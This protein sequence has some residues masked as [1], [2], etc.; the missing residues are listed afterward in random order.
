MLERE[1]KFSV[2]AGFQLPNIGERMRGR[3]LR[4]TYFDTTDYR[5]FSAGLTLRYRVVEGDGEGAWQLKLP[6]GGYRSEIETQGD[7]EAVPSELRELIAVL[8]RDRELRPVGTLVTQRSGRLVRRG[9]AVVA[10]VVH[11]RVT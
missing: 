8:V 7:L 10:E 9:D 6:S 11:D 3:T 4:S 2:P 5:L 1:R